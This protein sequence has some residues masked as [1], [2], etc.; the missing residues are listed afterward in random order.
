MDNSTLKD[1]VKLIVKDELNKS[2]KASSQSDKKGRPKK[3]KVVAQSAAQK[4]FA[5]RQKK[6]NE[7]YHTLDK[8]IPAKERKKMAWAH[9]KEE[10]EKLKSN[11]SADNIVNNGSSG[12]AV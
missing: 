3:K 12:S 2:A 7:Y 4:A 11:I 6:V 1:Y 8:N 10:E 9:V 5:E